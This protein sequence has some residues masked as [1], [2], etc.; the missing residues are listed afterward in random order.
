[1]TI[2]NMKY[3][4]HVKI[5][6]FVTAESD[7]DPDSHEMRIGL[8]PRFGIRICMEIKSWIWIRIETNADPQHWF[9]R[10]SWPVCPKLHDQS[11][12][13]PDT[14]TFLFQATAGLYSTLPFVLNHTL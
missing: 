12:I 6:L 1:M 13:L 14:F 9:N 3:I 2:T 10:K 8:A 7:Q 5:Q 11:I 4:F